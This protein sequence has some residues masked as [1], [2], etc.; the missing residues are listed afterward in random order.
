MTQSSPAISR[1]NFLT[2][3]SAAT[4]AACFNPRLLRAQELPEVVIRGRAAGATAKVTTQKLR[5]NVCALMGVG[6]NIAVLP[7]KD[8]KLLIDS[9][10]STS[11]PQLTEALAAISSDPITHLINTHWHFDHTD[12]NEWLHSAGATIIAHENCRTRLSTRQEITAFKAIFSPAPAGAIPTMVF[13]TDDTLKING[14]T[15]TL[16]H[17]DP[18]HTDTDISIY[19]AEANVLHVGDTWFNGFYPFIDY[20]TGGSIN[21]MIQ[22]TKRNLSAVTADTIIIPGHGPIG[23]K[24][25]LT[26]FHDMLVGVHDNVAALKK[27]GKSLDETVAAK[28]TSAYDAK[29]GKQPSAF[30][31]YVYQGV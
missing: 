30:I 16:R 24:A 12:G 10:Y 15:L 26:E 27:Q 17:F 4:A 28:P 31:G 11:R 6:G 22:A 7:G 2:I 23:N 25:Q 14:A 9:G 5:G 8:G 1:R 21:G 20:S 3:A 29:W 19:F 18:A 13:A